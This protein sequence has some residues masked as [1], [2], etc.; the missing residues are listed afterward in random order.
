MLNCIFQARSAK[1]A[2]EGLIF[3]REMTELSEK[4]TASFKVEVEG[5]ALISSKPLKVI[6]AGPAHFGLEL[7]GE[8]KVVGS[9]T[10]ANPLKACGSLLDV[11]KYKGKIVIAERGDCT[12]AD[13]VRKLQKE[14]AIGVIITDNVP[15]SS[16]EKSPLF[17]MSG[18]GENDITI[19]AL[20]LYSQ[21][22][23]I[24][25]H[26]ITEDPNAQIALGEYSYL[27][28]YVQELLLEK[29]GPFIDV[30]DF[31]TEADDS[32]MKAIKPR[33]TTK[34]DAP[35]GKDTLQ[36]D[37]PIRH[38]WLESII[39]EFE[40]QLF[41]VKDTKEQ[42]NPKVVNSLLK[43]MN[44]QSDLLTE[45]TIIEG[46]TKEKDDGEE[47][48]GEKLRK[49]LDIISDRMGSIETINQLLKDSYANI[50][51]TLLVDMT[52]DKII[53]VDKSATQEEIE[54]ILEDLQKDEFI[55]NSCHLENTQSE[56]LKIKSSK[57]ADVELVSNVKVNSKIQDK[58]DPEYTY[59]PDKGD[60]CPKQSK[61]FIPLGSDCSDASP[62]SKDDSIFQ[63]SDRLAS[64]GID[65]STDPRIEKPAVKAA[66]IDC[67]IENT[68]RDLVEDYPIEGPMR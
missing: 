59:V 17:A 23:D 48:I 18:D 10:F 60:K 4:S 54:Y 47:N 12:F 41:F 56:N 66:C 50:A 21:N 3:M 34:T 19:P 67:P 27:K 37:A 2:E 26:Y 14:G 6:S 61:A 33:L 32:V 63:S 9:A 68:V 15:G 29:I 58:P 57:E 65:Q 36:R 51:S 24:L 64:D 44:L 49:H 20:F 62:K 7:T 43:K 52:S 45:S 25:S 35:A 16:H 30:I 46:I 40:S 1:D 55:L 22:A 31:T 11:A 8:V 39:S 28:K 42:T 38:H 5:V 53:Q 13:K